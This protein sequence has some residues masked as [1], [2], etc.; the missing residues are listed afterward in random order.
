MIV[1]YI[2][3]MNKRDPKGFPSFEDYLYHMTLSILMTRRGLGINDEIRFYSDK[4][5]VEYL[6]DVL[7]ISDDR[8]FIHE[9]SEI[10][11]DITDPVV[12]I[13]VAAGHSQFLPE[14]FIIISDAI[15]IEDIS[16]LPPSNI[17][18]LSS[19][20]WSNAIVD[21]RIQD[22]SKSI[23][24]WSDLSGMKPESKY[25]HCSIIGGISSPVWIDLS[26]IIMI[27]EE[28]TSMM[29]EYETSVF[30]S[31][32][33]CRSTE[34]NEFILNDVAVR[35]PPKRRSDYSKHDKDNVERQLKAMFNYQL[36]ALEKYLT[37]NRIF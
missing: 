29:N 24:R 15:Y 21:S 27:K 20:H 33:F 14:R 31:N 9:I 16:S 11:D 28:Y 22:A 2:V 36:T 6:K 10:D 35:V 32:Y 26:N 7:S 30:V 37:K 19:I 8:I 18:F 17:Y 12:S 13:I 23:S 4:S 5:G 1:G 25:L 3:R 34:I